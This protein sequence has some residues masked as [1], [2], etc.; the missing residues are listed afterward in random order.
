MKKENQ[1]NQTI[2]SAHPT[3]VKQKI[4]EKEKES[5]F[6]VALLSTSNQT[7]QKRTSHS[8]VDVAVVVVWKETTFE[9]RVRGDD[10]KFHQL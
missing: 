5:F 4:V 8:V 2:V 1:K 9:K 7:E 6:F 10:P 3:I